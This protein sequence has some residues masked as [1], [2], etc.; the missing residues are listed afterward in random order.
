MAKI[1]TLIDDLFEDDEF[2]MPAEAFRAAGHEVFCVGFNPGETVVGKSEGF[3]AKIDQSVEDANAHEYDALLIPGGY[4]PDSLRS[5]V[6][7]QRIART[8]MELEKPVFT[9]CHGPQI[10]ISAEVLKGRKIT[11]WRSIVPDVKNAGAEYIDEPVV[12]D[13]NL[14]SS[15]MP[16]DIPDF[17][18][19]SMNI[20]G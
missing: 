15:R 13:R 10:L 11:C 20:I 17:I 9:I 5:D 4:S 12:V 3:Q 16:D 7:V 6:N 8:F 18:R 2:R 19:E 14:V 1:A